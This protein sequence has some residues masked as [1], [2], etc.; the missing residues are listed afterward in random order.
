MKILILTNKLPYPPRD[1]GSIA[2][3][4]MLTGLQKAGNHITCLSLNT[5]KHNFPVEKIP[6]ELSSTIRFLG[7]DCDSSI[8][9]L[10][11]ILNLLFSKKPYIAERFNIRNYREKL[12]ELL[13]NEPFDLVQLEGPYP[14]HY[15]GEIRKWCNA[16]VS[17][18][19]H[20]VEHL[21]WKRKAS[22]EKPMLKSWYLRNMAS[23]LE[24]FELQVARRSDYL[25]PI[26]QQD[27]TFFRERGYSRPILTIP[28][29]L[30]LE[31]YSLTPIPS[32]LTLFFIGA[33]DWLPNQEGLSWFLENVFHDLVAELPQL[34]FHVAGRNA[35]EHFVR[36]LNH[37]RIV[38]HGEV[39][40]ARKFMKSY[41]VMVAPLLTGSGIR[42][43]ILE[44]M[45]LGRPVVTS[46]VGIEGIP[47]E[48]NK[49][50]MLAN[51]PDL[52]RNQLVKLLTNSDE[53]SRLVTEARQ[54][55]KHNFDT[56]ELST[57]LSQFFKMQV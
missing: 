23:R 44:A 8:K 29:G 32:H 14:G 15:L 45:A 57:R 52:C 9:P 11:M 48:D 30:S 39:D 54:L 40:D 6:H 49:E 34:Q 7:V 10:R 35:P 2:T 22:R 12:A 5:S 17:L 24:K 18:R 25:I 33:L 38:Y 56:F 31:D 27:E 41:R 46:S 42:I 36:K 13:R 26:S 28:T 55:I 53:A 43:K 16:P 21:I 51:D 50:V 4:N 3:L 37:D 19:A 20:N 1:G 47:A